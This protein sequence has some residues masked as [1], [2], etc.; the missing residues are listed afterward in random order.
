MR[1]GA[2][3]LAAV[4]LGGGCRPADEKRTA[5]DPVAA[6]PVADGK[7]PRQAGGASA[8]PVYVFPGRCCPD[9]NL[10]LMAG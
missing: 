7:W 6:G 8:E 9:G 3:I 1:Q 4:V 10:R 5:P 2:V